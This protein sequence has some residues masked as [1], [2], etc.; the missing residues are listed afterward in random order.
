MGLALAEQAA[1]VI[2]SPHSAETDISPLLAARIPVVVIDRELDE[3]VDSV[4][5]DSRRR[6]AGGHR[7]PAGAGVEAPGVRH[8][9][10]LGADGEPAPSRLPGRFAC[11]LDPDVASGPPTV[12]DPR[13]PLGG[14]QPARPEPSARCPVRRQRRPRA[15]CP[16]GAAR[17]WSSHRSRVGL[18]CFDDAPWAPFI[19]PPI[20]V[21]SQPAYRM[22]A[23]AAA[24]LVERIGGAAHPPRRIV[25]GTDL[26][27]RESSLRHR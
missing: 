21:V 4:T 5:T 13:W 26:I 15:R 22:G 6:C 18:V 23:Q 3:P 17:P 1:G 25:L 14:G 20:S 10:A 12:H 27:V 19:D 16:A 7:T 11:R 9:A 8:R 24:L 2:V